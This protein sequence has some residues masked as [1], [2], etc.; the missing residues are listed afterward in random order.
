LHRNR[1]F[2]LTTRA[3]SGSGFGGELSGSGKKDLIRIQIRNTGA[4]LSTLNNHNILAFQPYSITMFRPVGH[5]PPK[6]ACLSAIKYY[7]V[8]PSKNSRMFMRGVKWWSAVLQVSYISHI[9]SK[10]GMNLKEYREHYGA[11]EEIKQYTCR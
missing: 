10:H 9:N 6:C 8:P 2:F 1:Y 5:K 4:R 7:S 11:Q 3:G